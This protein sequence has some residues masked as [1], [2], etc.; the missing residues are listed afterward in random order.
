MWCHL[1][2]CFVLFKKHK[3]FFNFVIILFACHVRR[4]CHERVWAGAGCIST[5]C[6]SR[7]PHSHLCQCCGH[8]SFHEETWCGKDHV[9][10]A[11]ETFP[12]FEREWIARSFG[13][14]RVSIFTDAGGRRPFVHALWLCM[15]R[16]DFPEQWLSRH[17]PAWTRDIDTWFHGQEACWMH[18]GNLLS[19]RMHHRMCK[20]R[21]SVGLLQLQYVD[22]M[23]HC[24]YDQI[25]MDSNG[26]VIA[27]VVYRA[28]N[29]QDKLPSKSDERNLFFV[30]VHDSM[31][32]DTR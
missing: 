11:L 7:L 5:I 8:R 2:I 30:P 13:H 17:C 25:W 32:W 31:N 16:K 27:C 3:D 23:C 4:Q 29:I 10:W 24:L 12:G 21:W 18:K 6:V 1:Q 20:N 14:W 26:Q 19:L 22:Y 9:S 15:G 28:W